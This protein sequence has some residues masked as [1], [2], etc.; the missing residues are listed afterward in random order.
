M[1]D[2]LD[3]KPEKD[4]KTFRFKT[5]DSKEIL[6]GA[7]IVYKGAKLMDTAKAGSQMIF[8]LDIS[9]DVA[10]DSLAAYLFARFKNHSDDIVGIRIEE[11]LVRVSEESLARAFLKEIKRSENE[12]RK[13]QDGKLTRFYNRKREVC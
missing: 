4:G 8:V 2:L 3:K 12:E 1:K 9:K 6:K 13:A 5:G 10:V 7:R 11:N